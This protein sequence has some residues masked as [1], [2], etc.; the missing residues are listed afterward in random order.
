MF[1]STV[2]RL[3]VVRLSSARDNQ[4]SAEHTITETIWDL[5]GLRSWEVFCGIIKRFVIVQNRAMHL[6]YSLYENLEHAENLFTENR[7]LGIDKLPGGYYNYIIQT[8]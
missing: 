3:H 6:L 7:R 4:F 8:F 1:A 5:P 2:S